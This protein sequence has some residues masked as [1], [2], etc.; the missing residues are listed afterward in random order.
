[1][2]PPSRAPIILGDVDRS[3]GRYG[4]PDDRAAKRGQAETKKIISLLVYPDA[5]AFKCFPI[6]RG[7]H[8]ALRNLGICEEF[9]EIEFWK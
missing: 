8:D 4:Y 2:I 9:R 3:L 5:M 7:Y 1:M 6:F